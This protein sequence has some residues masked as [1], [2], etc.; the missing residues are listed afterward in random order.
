MRL[1]F[2]YSLPCVP[3]NSSIGVWVLGFY[4]LEKSSTADMNFSAHSCKP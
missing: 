3:H 2:Q 4:L 1:I